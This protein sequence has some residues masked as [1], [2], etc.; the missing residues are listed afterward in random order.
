[1]LVLSRKLGEKVVVPAHEIVI[2]VLEILGN[3]VRL[4]IAAPDDTEVF[5]HEV[6]ER[7]HGFSEGDAEA[8]V[9]RVG[10]VRGAPARADH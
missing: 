4:G 2:K 7:L 5:R 9:V 10:E 3:K 6:W 1:M 8:T